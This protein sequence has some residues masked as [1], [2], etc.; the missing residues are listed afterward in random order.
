MDITDELVAQFREFQTEFSDTLVY[1]DNL[2]KKSLFEADFQ[3]SGSIWGVYT[4]QPFK[5]S[6]KALGM[7]YY[8]SHRIMIHRMSQTQVEAGAIAAPVA[9]IASQ[10]VSDESV[11]YQRSMVAARDE[12]LSSTTYG[13]DF[14]ALRDSFC[15]VGFQ[16]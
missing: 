3:T 4:Y 11:S 7:F 1:S 6:T 5:P 13:Q 9:P 10:S 15:F 12:Q 14:L 2:I 8:A 16:V